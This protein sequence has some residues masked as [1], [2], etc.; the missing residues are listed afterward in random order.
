MYVGLNNDLDSI[1]LVIGEVIIV[2]AL[3]AA[4]DANEDSEEEVE[5]EDTNDDSDNEDEL[6][7]SD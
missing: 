3:T 4:V 1:N 5:F 7:L 2:D 6:I